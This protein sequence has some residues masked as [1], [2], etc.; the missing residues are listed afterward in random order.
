MKSDW[1]Q[2]SCAHSSQTSNGQATQQPIKPIKTNRIQLLM[3]S[4]D[5]VLRPAML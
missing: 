4:D 2:S 3:V 1:S 5:S